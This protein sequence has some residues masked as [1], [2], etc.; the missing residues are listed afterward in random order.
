[1]FQLRFFGG[2]AAQRRAFLS[3]PVVAPLPLHRS[4]EEQL[5]ALGDKPGEVNADLKSRM[6]L[7]VHSLRAVRSLVALSAFWN[8]VSAA[9]VLIGV[10]CSRE[11]VAGGGS[12]AAAFVFSAGYLLSKLA[13][14]AIEFFDWR[15]KAQINR[16]VQTF[17]FR[18]VNAKLVS[19]DRSRAPEL[20]AGNLKT[21]IGSDVESVEDFLSAAIMQWV[22]TLV[23]LTVLAPALYFIGGWLGLTAL[24]LA[25]LSLPV[26]FVG[27]HYI[28][29]YQRRAQREQDRLTTL[30]GEWV[31]NIRLVRYLGWQRAIEKE[32]AGQMREFT[33]EF[34]VRHTIACGV[35]GLSWSWWM[36]PVLGVLIAAAW[37]GDAVTLTALFSIIWIL[38]HLMNYIQHL[39][40]SI[41]LYGAACA[42][43]DRILL[44]LK[45]ADVTESLR[46]RSQM[47][48]EVSGRPVR[49]KLRNVIVRFGDRVVIN[50][51]STTFDLTSRTAIVGAVG[52]GKTI[53]LELLVGEKA[54]DDGCID[55]EFDNGVTVPLWRKDAYELYRR[56]VAYTPSQPF[57]SNALM[58]L[59]VDLEGTQSESAL[60]RAT[61]RS[62]LAPDIAM[63]TKGYDEEVGETGINLS[64]GQ[65]QRV[66]LARAFISERPLFILDD[67]L[68]AVDPATEAL[69]MDELCKAAHGLIMVSH[70]L[71]ELSRCDRVIVMD[72]GQIVEDGSP[73]ELAS[74]SR[75]RFSAFLKAMESHER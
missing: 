6:E 71:Q 24:G 63:L 49:L 35:Y 32:I 11:V 53:L 64:G 73:L 23:M 67:P 2:F 30:I 38:D 7:F 43:A 40:Y 57:L 47:D 3:A 48:V 5:L 28:E 54:P 13:Q 37:T 69:L 56:N 50:N 1:M 36:V 66:S 18:I 27:A 68:S 59:N 4:I 22:P 61:M 62:Q 44:L 74:Q 58:R 52:S 15:R 60:E 65:R 45:A 21:L 25:L 51:I 9:I 19:L 31:R 42:G 34:A 14:A 17:L 26:A 16:G 55:V 70:R 12:L 29:R 39:P 10:F 20:S 46:P 8:A 75:S 41:S 72:E 33:R